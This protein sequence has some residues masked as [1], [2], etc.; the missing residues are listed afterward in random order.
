M[1]G[2]GLLPFGLSRA[3]AS[4]WLLTF[5]LLGW[6]LLVQLPRL[7][8]MLVL[9]GPRR[10]DP[11]PWLLSGAVLAGAGGIWTLHHPSLSQ[12]YFWL[13][14]LPFGAVL[15]V[16]LL[17]LVR[18]PWPVAV[19]AAVLGV[20]SYLLVPMM[21][22]P[23]ATMAGWMGVLG[24]SYLRLAVLLLLAALVA[25]GVPCAAGSAP[26]AAGGGGPW[27][28]RWPASR[29]RCWARASPGA[30]TEPSGTSRSHRGCP[31]LSRSRPR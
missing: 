22:R 6:W 10:A 23:A 26:T 11:A 27:R 31:R 21:P 29:R 4:G 16:W 8:G 18:P 24:R 2:G 25:I 14:V 5:V 20:A 13:D 17:T 30:S 15:T 9:A 1:R 12:V 7:I 28:W 19:S 3:G